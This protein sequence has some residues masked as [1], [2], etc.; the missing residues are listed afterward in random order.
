V[1][2]PFVYEPFIATLTH[3]HTHTHTQLLNLHKL[4]SPSNDVWP[5]PVNRCRKWSGKKFNNRNNW[6]KTSSIHRQW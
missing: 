1:T 2:I 3:T 4:C 6:T 5:K